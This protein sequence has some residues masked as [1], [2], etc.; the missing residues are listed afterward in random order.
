MA[1]NKLRGDGDNIRSYGSF[2]YFADCLYNGF[3]PLWNPYSNSGEPFFVI[4][5][6]CI[7]SG[8][9][10]LLFMVSL[11]KLLK[12][13]FLSLF[14]WSIFFRFVIFI[15]G[16]YFFFRQVSRYK[17]S[18]FLAF[19]TISFSSFNLVCL[20]GNGLAYVLPSYIFPWTFL[21]LLKFLEEKEIKYILPSIF[22]F[23]PFLG[24]GFLRFKPKMFL[25]NCKVSLLAISIFLLMTLKIV[26]EISY[27][28]KI[29]NIIREYIFTTRQQLYPN[30]FFP[31]LL[32]YYRLG[33]AGPLYFLEGDFL[34]I[35]LIPILLL[36]LGILFSPHRY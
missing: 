8:E 29:V 4:Y 30:D 5:P 12:V 33:D 23:T 7:R 9:M 26:P 11:G 1:N 35:G 2:Y 31:L 36:I 32:P 34:Y 24:K 10:D 13:S 21:F 14:T 20:A 25:T 19:L 17:I 27:I 22:F 6:P 28:P 16:C 15:S 18:A 3:L